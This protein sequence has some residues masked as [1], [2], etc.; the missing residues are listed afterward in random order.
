MEEKAWRKGNFPTPF[1][2]GGGVKIGN[3][4]DGEQHGDSLKDEQKR[5]HMIQPSHS[6]TQ[7]QRQITAKR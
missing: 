7:V 5:Y 2:E 3:S 4:H 6:W 1:L